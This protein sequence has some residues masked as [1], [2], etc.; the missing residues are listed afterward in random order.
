MQHLVAY[1]RWPGSACEKQRSASPYL[2]ACLKNA[3]LDI[4]TVQQWVLD[5]RPEESTA[6]QRQPS[7]FV[8]MRTTLI[9]GFSRDPNYQIWIARSDLGGGRR[10]ARRHRNDQHLSR[11]RRLCRLPGVE[12]DTAPRQ[13][14]A[15]GPRLGR[16]GEP[17]R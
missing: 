16:P 3:F 9:G 12:G 17:Q 7:R 13:E 15:L 6:S 5:H 8:R 1:A 14:P 2:P 11:R 4:L 10:F